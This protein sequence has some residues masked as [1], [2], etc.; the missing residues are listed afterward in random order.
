MPGGAANTARN[1][2]ALGARTRLIS[3]VGGD[4]AGQTLQ[5]LLSKTENIDAHL[6]A[7]ADGT[8]TCKT[9]LVSGGQQLLRLD[10]DS[11]SARNATNT[12]DILSATVEAA[13]GATIILVSDYGKG[14]VTPDLIGAILQA[15]LEHD[16][17]IIVDPKGSDIAKYGPV[18]L[19]KPNAAELASMVEMPTGTDVEVEAALEMAM[20][21]SAA[22]AILVTRAAQGLSYLE[23]GGKV[24][25]CK[26]V[27]RMVYDVSGAGD[28]VLAALGIARSA[29]ASLEVAAE[30]ALLA[31]G[32]AVEK[33]GTATLRP[34]ELL[35]GKN[36]KNMNLTN[37]LAKV[38][39]WRASGQSVGFTNGCFD[40]LHPGH[41]RV[42]EEAKARCGR[43]IVGLNS[44]ASVERLKGPQRPVNDQGARA[45]MLAGLGVVDG[46]IVF[47]EDTPAELIAALK[48]DLL[49]K[50]GDY[51]EDTIIGADTVKQSGGDIYIVPLL[52]GFSTT[53]TIEKAGRDG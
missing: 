14:F 34:A 9:R 13:E 15:G 1:L 43:L 25:H 16:V 21:L 5:N 19:I 11:V 48:P 20:E 53:A 6:F 2:A 23:R 40:I 51:S 28:T 8:T 26:T 33:P 39:T 41:L 46:V 36:D 37:M 45:R 29:G 17:P 47:E 50:G 3:L 18:D 38:E 27:E 10:R 32:L 42:L 22:R 49:V 52:E 24:E 30:L 44:D 4:D 7:D 35:S 12:D 31:S